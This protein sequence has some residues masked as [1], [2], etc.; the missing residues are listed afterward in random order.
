MPE[1]TVITTCPECNG[2]GYTNGEFCTTCFGGGT[3]PM[4]GNTAH[5]AKKLYDLIS[6]V[7]ILQAK[8]DMIWDVLPSGWKD[9]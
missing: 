5:F 9:V 8:V 6:K 3:V 1:E 7:D 2:T 4:K